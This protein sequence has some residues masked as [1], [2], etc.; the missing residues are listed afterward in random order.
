VVLERL[1]PGTG[2]TITFDSTFKGRFFKFSNSGTPTTVL[3]YVYAFVNSTTLNCSVVAGAPS[4]I[5]ATDYGNAAGTSY[6]E[7]AWDDKKGYP[8]AV[9]F[10]SQRIIFGGSQAFPDTTWYSQTANVFNLMAL[11]FQQDA[12]YGTVLA[13]SPFGATLKSE[14]INEIRWLLARKTITA[15]TNLGEHTIYGPD[16]AKSIGPTNFDSNQETPHGSAKVQ[17][18]KLENATIFVQRGRA[19]VRELVYNLDEASFQASNLSI[20]SE[21]I[22]RKSAGEYDNAASYLNL[23]SSSGGIV[24]MAFQQ[25]PNGIVWCLDANGTLCAVTRERQQQVSAWHYHKIAGDGYLTD[26]SNFPITVNNAYSPRVLSISCN[27]QKEQVDNSAEQDELWMTVSRPVKAGDGFWYERI[28][29]EK[30]MPEWVG[31]SIERNW[32]AFT[33]ITAPQKAPVYMDCS[34]IYSSSRATIDGR[35]AGEIGPLPQGEGAV[36][37]VVANGRYLGEFTVASGKIN[38]LSQLPA[39]TTYWEAIVGFKY[40]GEIQPLIPEV[41][42]STGSSQAQMRRVDQISVF[43][44]RSIGAKYG[45]ATST[46]EAN[47]PVD[48]MESISFPAG[49]T[50]NAP[51]PLYTGLKTVN[52]PQSYERRPSLLIQSSQPLPFI[53]THIVSRMVVNE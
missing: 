1:R 20:L 13:T 32:S 24:A 7:C 50:V 52:F 22:T 26:F 16:S 3:V 40:V 8:R 5:G 33:Q 18:L 19:E 47:T 15:G 53:V 37:S 48:S 44:Y 12:G 43:F 27:V 31:A 46:E 2:S 25:T 51:T 28:F 41:P 17:A 4:T 34:Y 6:E 45:R 21:H 14:V 35:P 39:G 11:G 36:V 9:T 49:A 42:T 29:I 30:M 23:K 38:I 10:Y